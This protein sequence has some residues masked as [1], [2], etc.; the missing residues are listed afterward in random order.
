MPGKERD[1]ALV[2]KPGTGTPGS[3]YQGE[4][5]RRKA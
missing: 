5:A 3:P 4:L 2:T 1:A